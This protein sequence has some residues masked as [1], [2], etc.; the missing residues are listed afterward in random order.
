M[1]CELINNPLI[2]LA[3]DNAREIESKVK[4][5]L[6]NNQPRVTQIAINSYFYNC[7]NSFAYWS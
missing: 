6:L 4:T 3:L 5:Q 7:V 1:Y 2:L